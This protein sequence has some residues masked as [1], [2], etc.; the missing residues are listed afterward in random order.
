MGASVHVVGDNDV[1]GCDFFN[2]PYIKLISCFKHSIGLI[3]QRE[4]AMF[5]EKRDGKDVVL[6]EILEAYIERV[7]GMI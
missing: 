7:R 4:I 6:D 1:R 5:R 2:I 3:L